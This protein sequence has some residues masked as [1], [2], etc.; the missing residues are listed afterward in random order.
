MHRG[1]RPTK[2]DAGPDIIQKPKLCQREKEGKRVCI[3]AAAAYRKLKQERLADTLVQEK[4][5]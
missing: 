1:S 5:L 4:K 3:Q 2:P